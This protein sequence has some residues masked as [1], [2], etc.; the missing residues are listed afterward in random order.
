MDASPSVL[1]PCG[2]SVA[3]PSRT[4]EG[5]VFV[6]AMAVCAVFGIWK[7]IDGE[8][9]LGTLILLTMLPSAVHLRRLIR[10]TTQ[11]PDSPASG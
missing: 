8:L 9:W 2:V 6:C 5:V 7:L 4:A 1:R 11:R 3:G 10:K